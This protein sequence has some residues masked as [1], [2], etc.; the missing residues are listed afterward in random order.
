MAP[1]NQAISNFDP[2][3]M[4]RHEPSTTRTIT[5]SNYQDVEPKPTRFRKNKSVRFHQYSEVYF[6]PNLNDYTNEEI[7]RSWFTRRDRKASTI[8]VNN[9]IRLMREEWESK[10][11]SNTNK[12]STIID[13]VNHTSRGTECRVNSA[14]R[15][16]QIKMA[17][18]YILIAQHTGL[19]QMNATA[20]FAALEYK[21]LSQDNTNEA[22]KQGLI[23]QKDAMKIRFD[24]RRRSAFDRISEDWIVSASHSLMATKQ[25]QNPEVG[26]SPGKM[27]THAVYV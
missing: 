14:R 11:K 22:R 19:F 10:S 2:Y 27:W 9:T 13:D 25:I 24:D 7:D 16:E 12:H 18:T 3:L 8:D 1:L 4:Y 21:R 17:R 5:S 20:A 6:I 23:D 15:M 26:Y